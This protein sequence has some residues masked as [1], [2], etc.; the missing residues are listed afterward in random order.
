MQEIGDVKGEMLTDF[1]EDNG[2]VTKTYDD[3]QYGIKVLNL[4]ASALTVE[5]G[6]FTFTVLANSEFREKFS[7]GFKDVTVTATTLF[8][9]FI[10]R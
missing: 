7:N 8:N 5:V 2:T 10:Y 6:G 3:Y 4:G 1:F 9:A